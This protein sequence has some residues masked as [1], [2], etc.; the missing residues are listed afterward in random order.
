MANSWLRAS[1]KSSLRLDQYGRR[2][3]TST[4]GGVL[5][6]EVVDDGVRECRLGACIPQGIAQSLGINVSRSSAITM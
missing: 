3:M 6:R 2:C 4:E 1:V 5:V